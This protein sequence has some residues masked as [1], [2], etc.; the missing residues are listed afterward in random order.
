M[1]I[2]ALKSKKNMLCA[3]KPEQNEN[4]DLLV[5]KNLSIYYGCCGI[6][7]NLSFSIKSGGIV[8]IIG[9]N[10]SGKST[11]L[12]TLA[13][14]HEHFCGGFF[15]NLP[16]G[17]KKGIGYLPQY[18]EVN[19]YLSIQVRDVVS[20]GVRGKKKSSV[21]HAL[22]CLGLTEEASSF[23]G[24]LSG[25][26]FQRMLFARLFAME[27]DIFLLDEPFVSMD[28][29]SQ[30]ILIEQLFILSKK[31][32]TF[33][34]AHHQDSAILPYCKYILKLLPGEHCWSGSYN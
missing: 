12:R 7:E 10:G 14:I 22:A 13:G 5:V 15:W 29:A 28:E 16:C 32:K 30:D 17:G 26:Q 18:S 33:F 3:Q 21:D 11:F 23:I 8:S 25:G 9:K 4:S 19:R 31:G 2:S 20:M 27:L 24:T 1:I 34:L 6:I